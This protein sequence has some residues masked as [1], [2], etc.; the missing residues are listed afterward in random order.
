VISG[1]S[2]LTAAAKGSSNETRTAALVG[3]EASDDLALI[4][5]DPTGLVSN[6]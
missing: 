5:V 1:A 6:R 2:S 3:E 4:K